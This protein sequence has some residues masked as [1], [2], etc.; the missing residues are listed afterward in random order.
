LIA[1]INGLLAAC[2]VVS[3]RCLIPLGRRGYAECQLMQ[4]W[5]TSLPELTLHLIFITL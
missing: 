1:N 2:N 4:A 5:L 3:D